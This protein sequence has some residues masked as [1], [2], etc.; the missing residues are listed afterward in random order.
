MA[1]K[2]EMGGHRTPE[3][4]AGHWAPEE[5]AGHWGKITYDSANPK[6]FRFL[7]K[8][9]GECSRENVIWGRSSQSGH[10]EKRK[11]KTENG[12]LKRE[13]ESAK[14]KSGEKQKAEIVKQI[15]RS[16]AL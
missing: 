11:E 1:K 8:V 4:A 13:T 2:T 5:A 10:R 16:N 3:E 14:Q 9:S 15:T 6:R 12:K 7:G